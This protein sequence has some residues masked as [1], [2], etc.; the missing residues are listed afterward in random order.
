MPAHIVRRDQAY[1][2]VNPQLWRKATQ[3]ENLDHSKY[4]N[5]GR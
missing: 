3:I 4:H 5:T 1:E 2:K